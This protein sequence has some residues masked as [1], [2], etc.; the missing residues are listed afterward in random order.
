MASVQP[1]HVADDGRW[2][3]QRIGPDRARTTY[4]FRSLLD[5]GTALAFGSDWTVAPLNPF[6]GI[7]AAVPRQTLG[8]AHPGGWMT[9]QRIE[10]EEA[11]FAYTRTASR[12]GFAEGFS[13]SLAPGKAADFV[14]LDRDPFATPETELGSVRVSRTF[15]EGKE[16][17]RMVQDPNPVRSA[18]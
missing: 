10:L 1:Y 16:V 3:A 15:V 8:G 9:A 7:E 11:L 12:A 2:A 13:G 5:A 14:V 4:A 18:S 6:P 17:Y